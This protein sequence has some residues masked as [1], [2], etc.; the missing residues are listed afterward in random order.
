MV[1]FRECANECHLFKENFLS[2][3]EY[4]P[5][6]YLHI[7]PIFSTVSSNQAFYFYQITI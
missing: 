1:E 3:K 5:P 4:P 6:H 7:Q 2:F